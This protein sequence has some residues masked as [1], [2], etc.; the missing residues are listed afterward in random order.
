MKLWFTA[1]THFGHENIIEFCHRPFRNLIQ[2]NET[3]VSNWNERVD[4]DDTVIIIGDF[5]FRNTAGGKKGEGTV[6]RA[7]HYMERLNGQKVFIR[8][9]HD[10]NNSLNTKIIS[11]EL[12]IG[13]QLIQCIHNPVDFDSGYG[14]V[15]CG[16][17]HDFWEIRKWG[18]TYLVNVGVDVWNFR[19]VDIN[20]I[21]RRL[22]QFMKAEKYELIKELV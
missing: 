22:G 20:E 3:M 7:K 16:H 8:G 15:L 9:N 13:G 6:S 1:D 2:M 19:P 18:G 5:C 17:V 14:I 12:E 11:L 10:G 4:D 21:M